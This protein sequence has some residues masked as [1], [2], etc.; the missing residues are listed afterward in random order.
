MVAMSEFDKAR[1]PFLRDE[2]WYPPVSLKS[3]L[4]ET[5]IRD[6]YENHAEAGRL[7]V[8]NRWDAAADKALAAGR[9]PPPPCCW[10]LSGL[11]PR[12]EVFLR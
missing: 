3:V 7:L 12:S 9:A 4:A 2:D 5:L 11:I 6:A 8:A 1:Y 10:R